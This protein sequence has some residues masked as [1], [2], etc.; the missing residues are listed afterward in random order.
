MPKNS[1]DAN[2][3]WTTGDPQKVLYEKMLIE[4]LTGDKEF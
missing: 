1:V 4:N 2:T 3:M